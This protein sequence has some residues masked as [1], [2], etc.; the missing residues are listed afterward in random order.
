METINIG[1]ETEQVEYKKST[2]EMKEAVHSIVAMLN[3]HGGGELYFGVKNNGDVIGQEISETTLRDISQAISNHIKPVIY[4]EITTKRFG[5]LEVAYVKFEGNRAPYLAY[6]IPRIRVSDEDKVMDQETYDDMLRWR[7]DGTKAWEL[8]VSDYT[9][10][11]VDMT[12]FKRY[13]QKAKSVGRIT[14]DSEEPRA[15]MEK[16]ELC[17]GN[18]RLLNAGAALFCDKGLN[19][20][21]MAKFAGNEKITFTDIRRYSGSILDLADKAEQY[22]IDAMDWKA[23]IVGLTREETP[24]IPVAAIREAIINAFAHRLIESRQSVEIEIF[25]NRI[26]IFSPGIY[27]SNVAPE[28]YIKEDRRAVRRNP[29]IAKTLYYS[30]DMETFATGFRRI[31]NLC[32]EAGCRVSFQKQENGFV[33]V[34]YRNL[35]AVWNG[36]NLGVNGLDNGFNLGV[37]GVDDGVNLGVNSE[38]NDNISEKNILEALKKNPR[39]SQANLS[40]MLG[41]PYRTLQRTMQKMVEDGQ[42]E[43]IGGTR[44]YWGIKR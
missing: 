15:V 29:L 36:V 28:I 16:L 41:I 37:K 3:K 18:Y 2:S 5:D 27:A 42:I 23:E 8:Q 44:G 24:E 17:D 12:A 31:Q 11:D 9:V 13:L 4:P 32:D 14:F 40:K 43:R 38:E 7:S 30:K 22:L 34:F 10:D 19:D 26:E 25:K 6:N 20:L 21:Q 33:V 1:R 35:R 39:E